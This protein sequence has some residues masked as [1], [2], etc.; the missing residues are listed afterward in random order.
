M[1]KNLTQLLLPLFLLFLCLLSPDRSHSFDF[2]N[3]MDSVKK[4]VDTA[5][6]DIAP[7]PSNP[8]DTGAAS[9]DEY[10]RQQQI[11]G[12]VDGINREIAS[13]K[14]NL[15]H[16]EKSLNEG[17]LH[18]ANSSLR[19][20]RSNMDRVKNAGGD[21]SSL[22]SEYSVLLKR[23][24]QENN[25]VVNAGNAEQTL[26]SYMGLLDQVDSIMNGIGR[27]GY[28]LS[29]NERFFKA[30]E[31][32]SQKKASADKAFPFVKNSGTPGRINDFFQKTLPNFIKD[33]FNA[34]IKDLLGKANRSNSLDDARA[35]DLMC[36]AVLLLDPANEQAKKFKT[37][38]AK[39]L[40]K[41]GGSLG[42]ADAV[43]NAGK[44]IFS[45]TPG[46]VPESKFTGKD[47]IYAT[48]YLTKPYSG[49]QLDAHLMID[50]DYKVNRQDFT[51]PK[52]MIGKSYTM[53]EVSPDPA[54]AKQQGG[55][56]YTKAFA[57]LA[58]GMTYKVK[59]QYN[60]SFDGNS[61]GEFE[62][63]LSDGSAFAERLNVYRQKALANTFMKKAGQKNLA[64]EKEI[65][66]L[67]KKDAA[68]KGE[69]PLRVILVENDWRIQRHPLTGIIEYRQIWADVAVK[70]NGKCYV[71]ELAYKQDYAGKSYGKL[72]YFSI[73]GTYEILEANVF[74]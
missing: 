68:G 31:A 35:A 61:E 28:S 74:K 17:D 41:V 52:E 19:L 60:G 59:L 45:K 16:A 37:V 48:V 72:Q 39:T 50:N 44:I 40:G 71:Y 33:D 12:G 18:S 21:P 25:A 9:R 34:G 3:L 62:L 10:V 1:K 43:K 73:F 6:P 14:S 58:E 57:E 26:V 4:T 38:V 55:K 7:S 65:L 23:A 42:G 53:T 27:G 46:G 47:F 64:L 22:E 11:Q 8:P 2:G 30:A 36:D 29:N 67:F 70:K 54:T 24:G 63:D 56:E 13:A 15:N 5:T 66:A 69:T 20:A 32:A 49:K 51:L